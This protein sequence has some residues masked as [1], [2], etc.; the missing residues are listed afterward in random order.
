[1]KSLFAGAI[2]GTFAFLLAMCA[3]DRA[4]GDRFFFMQLS[5]PQLGMY[6]ADSSFLQETANLE[7]AVATANRLRPAF[8]VVTGDLVNQMGNKDQMAEYLRITSKLDRSIPLYNVPGN[9]DIGNDPTPASIEAYRKRFGPD[10]YSFRSGDL[11][12]IVLNSSLIHS[13]DKARALYEEQE[14]WLRAELER[15]RDDRARHIVVFQHHPLYLQ[16]ADEADEYSNIPRARRG[17]YVELLSEFG[18]HGVISGHNHASTVAGDRSLWMVSSGSVGKPFG[19]GRSG[20]A[21]VTVT[22]SGI[23]HRFYDFGSLPSRVVIP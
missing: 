14:K 17:R 11:V 10:H 23:D 12:G 22:G 2:Y 8:V 7:M 6:M 18:V 4:A 3:G 15:A 19:D 20:L 16:T 9:H 13:P 1:M 5:D 21:I